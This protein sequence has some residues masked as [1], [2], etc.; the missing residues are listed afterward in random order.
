LVDDL[1]LIRPRE[2]RG[3]ALIAAALVGV[4]AIAFAYLRPVMRPPYVT[5]LAAQITIQSWQFAD[6]R[7]GWVAVRRQ[8][9]ASGRSAL[10]ATHD[11]GATWARLSLQVPSAYVTWLRVFDA[12]HGMVQLA[13]DQSD[14]RGSLL[15][16]DDGGATWHDLRLP[17]QPAVGTAWFLDRQHGWFLTQAAS[18][19]PQGTALT[20][21]VDGGRTWQLLWRMNAADPDAGRGLPWAGHKGPLTFLTPQRG[22]IAAAELD[23]PLRL[24]GTSDGGAD[25]AP[26][27]LPDISPQP[28][29]DT[30]LPRAVATSEVQAFSPAAVGFASVRLDEPARLQ[31]LG[32][33]YL[34]A[35]LGVT[36]EARPLP[37]PSYRFRVQPAVLLGVDRWWLADGRQLWTTSDGGHHWEFQDAILPG[38]AVL[39]SLQAANAGE[40]WSAGWTSPAGDA[41][42]LLLRT[43]DGGAHWS[44]V[45]LPRLG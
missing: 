8:D 38:T 10:F 21:T 18:N 43:I 15:A 6:S 29:P 32:W 4:A 1:R 19:S 42:A 2:L 30:G 11:G 37:D 22:F 44:A 9:T 33:V 12:D 25:W 39:G 5:P 23:G 45:R 31:P 20:R 24:F 41:D 27:A 40:A 35:D 13:R 26:V 16:T 17:D 14:G 34:S 36:W 7:N 28:V 3:A